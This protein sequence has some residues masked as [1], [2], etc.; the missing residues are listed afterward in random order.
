MTGEK[1][2]EVSS[3]NNILKQQGRRSLVSL[4]LAAGIALPLLGTLGLLNQWPLAIGMLLG[5]TAAFCLLSLSRTGKIV[6]WGSLIAVPGIFLVSGG[7]ETL[8]ATC[9]AFIMQYSG[10]MIAPLYG[11]ELTVLITLVSALLAWA[12]SHEDMGLIPTV[13]ALLLVA[14]AIWATDSEACAVTM[15]PGALAA[16][17]IAAGNRAEEAPLHRV[18]PM[19][20]ALAL[21]G[22]LVSLSGGMTIEPMHQAAVELR[23]RIADYLFF[24]APRNVFS[25][26]AEGY[27][28]QGVNQ[29]GG[30]A[31]PSDRLVM[32]VETPRNAYLRGAIKNEY[33]G[34]SWYDTTGGRRYL[35][36]SPRWTQERD[37]AFDMSL[38]PEMIRS[39]SSL[40]SE[41]RVTVRMADGSASSLFVPQ[42]VRSLSTGAD[43]VPYFNRGSEIFTT[44]DLLPGDAYTVTAPLLTA[45]EVGLD[46]II[47]ACAG[48]SDPQ[49]AAIAKTY[50]TLPAH[51]QDIVLQLAA[52]ICKD[53]QTPYEKAFAIQKYLMRSYRYTLEVE[54]QPE[55]IDFVT[56]FL[57]NTKEGYCTYFASAMTVL[58]RMVGLPARYVEGYLAE[59]DATGVAYVTGRNGHAWT[60]V[61]FNGFGWLTFD[62]TPL[63]SGDSGAQAQLPPEALNEESNEATPTPTTETQNAN[64][65]PTPTPTGSD[66]Q[67]NNGDNAETPTPVI[68]PEETPVHSPE[69]DDTSSNPQPDEHDA[70][71]LGWLWWL[72]LLLLL[73]TSCAARI[74]TTMPERLAARSST[75][76]D[77]YA[78]WLQA[79]YDVLCLM[80]L[81][82]AKHESPL[83]Y[84]RRVDASGRVPVAMTPI[85]QHVS[86]VYYGKFIPTEAELAELRNVWLVL[87]RQM[88]PVHRIR[89]MLTRAVVP[90]KKRSF[91]AR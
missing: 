64:A 65:T 54:P 57:F 37:V 42:R 23:D 55:N 90:M 4:L 32:T 60:E 85:G 18:L 67:Q 87:H 45:G 34:R 25:L 22:G 68:P 1:K 16:L 84:M 73:I 21:V 40:L 71:D 20:L 3:L 9:K 36:V 91:L 13:F 35:W 14:V 88:K 53:A 50:T 49:Y 83:A 59:P 26:A 56:N 15:V 58:C 62:A 38:P 27:Y 39:G 12:M 77:V 17:L 19:A 48:V 69:T 5:V 33:T 86:M 47:N 81:R 74:L 31:E 30:T 78:V 28:P 11:T 51:M 43:A 2:K 82:A 80:G 8:T 79:V 46:T 66:E 52:D 41:Q 44:R 10:Y 76:E 7:A 61:Y 29:L 63:T 6:L 75:E 24:T 89:L 70:P 72:L